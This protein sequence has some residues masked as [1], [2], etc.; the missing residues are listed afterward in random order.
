MARVTP[1]EAAEKMVRRV[2]A[3]GPDIKRGIERVTEAPGVKAAAAQDLMLARLTESVLS[4]KWADAVAA[5]P[6][7]DW[8]K[9]AIE[10]GLPRIAQGI[11]AAQP[12]IVT[13]MTQLLPAVDAAKAEIEAM[14]NVTLDDRIARSAAFQRRMAGF[15]FTR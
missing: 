6:L 5:V 14:P 11:S 13:F 8:K 12:K 7:A 4:G 2:S 15:R 1:Q 3:A 9:A 10:K